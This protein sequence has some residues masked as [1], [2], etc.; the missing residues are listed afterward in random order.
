MTWERSCADWIQFWENW[1]K[2]RSATMENQHAMTLTQFANFVFYIYSSQKFDN[3]RFNIWYEN[4]RIQGIQYLGPST[5]T[6]RYFI[7]TAKTQTTQLTIHYLCSLP[8]SVSS[9]HCEVVMSLLLPVQRLGCVK[10]ASRGVDR[11]PVIIYA[12]CNLAVWAMVG[13]FNCQLQHGSERD[14]QIRDM[15][16]TCY[17]KSKKCSVENPFKKNL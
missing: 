4:S 17:E 7:P 8:S 9:L 13:I 1:S 12:K 5:V 11:K 3:A 14:A 16:V 6:V 2:R 10:D 15:R